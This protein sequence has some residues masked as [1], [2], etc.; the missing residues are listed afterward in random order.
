MPGTNVEEPRWS[1]GE[2]IPEVVTAEASADDLGVLPQTIN[3]Y[4]AKKLAPVGQRFPGTGPPDAPAGDVLEVGI[5]FHA[6]H[7]TR[8]A[9]G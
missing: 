4:V 5:D 1:M 7:S 8:I 9:N 6:C 3:H 2:R